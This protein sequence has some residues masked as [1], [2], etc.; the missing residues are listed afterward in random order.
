L[1][2]AATENIIINV[3]DKT[4]NNHFLTLGTC[5]RRAIE[6]YLEP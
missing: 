3:S 5:E 6:P 2:V 1:W 4:N